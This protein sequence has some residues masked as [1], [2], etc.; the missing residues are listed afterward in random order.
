MQSS[1]YQ[2]RTTWRRAT[3]ASVFV[4]TV[5]A[6]GYALATGWAPFVSD[7]AAVVVRGGTVSVLTNG[8]NNVLA[9]DWDFE[10]DPMT[11]SLTKESKHGTVILNEDGTFVYQ[12]DGSDKDKDEF[13]YR[14]FDGT[15]LSREARVKIDIEVPPNNPPFTIGSPPA[16]EAI[17]NQPYQLALI[18]YFGDSDEGDSLTFSASGLPDNRRFGIDPQSAL[19]TGLPNNSD[20]R[21]TPYIVTITA[22]DQGGLSVSL[23]F[24]LAVLPDDRADLKVSAAL[25][26][27]PISVGETARWNIDVENLGPSD[28]DEGELTVQWLTSGPNLSL[29][30]PSGCSLNGNN[31]RSPSM[32]CSVDGLRAKVTASFL[33]EGTQSGDGDNSLVAIAIADDP[34]LSNNS[35]VTGAQVVAA[36]SEGPT[37]TVSIPVVSLASADLDGDGLYDVIA[38]TPDQTSVYFNSGNRT[39][40]TPGTALGSSSGGNAVVTLD[41]NA[42]GLPDVAVAGVSGSVARVWLNDG[43]G[44]VADSIDLDGVNVGRV[45]A[46]AA[47]D[48]DLDGNDDLVVS[49]QND[50]AVFLS[51]GGTSYTSRS[52][53]GSGGVDI[54]IAD[55][56]N[57]AYPDAIMVDARDRAVRLMTNSGNGRDYSSQRLVRGSVSGV[58]AEDLNGDGDVDLLLAIDGEDLELPESKIVLQRSDGTFPAG[59]AIG[60]SALRKMIAGDVDGDSIADIITLND[61]GVH[62]MYKGGSGGGFDLQP[63]QIV[64]NGMQSIVLVDFNNDQSLD[65]IMGGRVAGVLEIHANNGIGR[66]GLGDRVAPVVSLVGES[67]LQLPAGAVWEDPGATATDDIDGDLSGAVVRSGAFDP[68]V[69]GT[70]TLTYQAS[71]RA[72]NLGSAQRVVQVGVNAGTGGSGGGQVSPLFLVLLALLL[73]L[74]AMRRLQRQT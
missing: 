12:H 6:S 44:G 49:G 40:R 42:D 58:S 53:P 4:A 17:E 74:L 52:L 63:E 27:N 29:T 1:S 47:G 21:N 7:D 38:A 70:Y 64:S 24:P 32:R 9:N 41:W 36:F 61:A 60:A 62:Q 51:S 11:A 8:S 35:I 30:A 34:V 5:L 22:R 23:S 57:D 31:S 59:S 16:Q 33:V 68:G 13:K 72:G 19:L 25:A 50:A 66:L 15:G 46:A 56:D 18:G 45:Y 10:G 14:A 43:S 65:L 37:Q 54:T 69:V 39:L 55:L 28:A 73:S 20:V 3:V 48:L 71:D 2:S 26:A 67:N